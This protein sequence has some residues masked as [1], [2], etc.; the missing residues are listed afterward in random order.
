MKNHTCYHLAH[1]GGLDCTLLLGTAA[2]AQHPTAFA[3]VREADESVQEF[4]PG[5]HRARP[6]MGDYTN[7]GHKYLMVRQKNL[8]ALPKKIKLPG[9]ERLSQDLG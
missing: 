3:K 6:V 4:F 5:E 1:L 9:A 8:S 7:T 2:G